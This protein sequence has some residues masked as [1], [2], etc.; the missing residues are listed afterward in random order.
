MSSKIPSTPHAIEAEQALLGSLIMEST[1]WDKIS[2][3]ILASDFFDSKNRIIFR[4]IGDLIINGQVIDLLILEESLKSKGALNEAGGREYLASLTRI[5]PTHAH[6]SQYAEIIKEKSVA[7]ELINVST[8]TI[9][10]VHQGDLGDINT[11]LDRAEQDIFKIASKS[12]GAYDLQQ[13]GPVVKTYIEKVYAKRD[14]NELDYLL[15]GYK[16]LD[17]L[18]SGFQ[19]SDLIIIAGR[20]SMGKT[21]FAMNVAQH[22]VF[23]QKKRVGFFSLEM[24]SEAIALRM[25]SSLSSVSQQNIRTGDYEKKAGE[26][27]AVTSAIELMNDC[28][29]YVDDT[30]G[31]SPMELRSKARRLKRGSGIDVIIVDYL[32]L[33]SIPKFSENRVNE[34]GEVTR[35]LKALAKELDVPVI[36]LSQLNRGVESRQDK[37]PFLSDLRESGSIEQDADLITFLYRD[38]VYNDD[39]KFKNMAEVIVAKHRNGPIGTINLTWIPHSTTFQDYH[40]QVYGDGVVN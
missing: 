38:E 31:I 3:K 29:F 40:P 32:Q 36:A 39:S 13:I 35:A 20:P 7:R 1:S 37:R 23:K 6:I 22:M 5:V 8:S 2:D 9:Q 15:T 34:I 26:T 4:E 28:E 19:K 14:S 24:S 11:I 10:N 33:M 12:S 17:D 21:A 25:L 30:A 18:I 16:E 27:T